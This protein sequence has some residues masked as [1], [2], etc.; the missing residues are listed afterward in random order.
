M[1]NWTCWGWSAFVQATAAMVCMWCALSSGGANDMPEAKAFRRSVY[2][3]GE[4]FRVSISSN[5]ARN[6]AKRA[7]I[8]RLPPQRPDGAAVAPAPPRA[9]SGATVSVTLTWSHV[10]AD[11]DPPIY[12]PPSQDAQKNSVAA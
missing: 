5:M 10:L 3:N 2:S 1:G 12:G 11:L 4:R 8:P 9:R 7:D 6:C